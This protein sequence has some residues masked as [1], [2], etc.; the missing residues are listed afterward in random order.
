MTR[1]VFLDGRAGGIFQIGDNCE[2]PLA[3]EEPA[4]QIGPAQ[5][6]VDRDNAD[7]T[8]QQERGAVIKGNGATKHA[9]IA[10]PHEFID[11]V[12]RV[13]KR[14]QAKG[15]ERSEPIQ[16]IEESHMVVFKD[17]WVVS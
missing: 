9:D 10:A 8:S 14:V 6:L 11:H 15:E 13:V 1:G 17:P 12:A 4:K 3:S 2:R 7:R 5:H 16:Q